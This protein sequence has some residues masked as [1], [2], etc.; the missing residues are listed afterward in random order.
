MDGMDRL[1]Y[2]LLVVIAISVAPA[3]S[4]GTSAADPTERWWRGNTHTHTYW[5][6]G[7]A[8][9]EQAVGWYAEHGYHFVVLSDHNIMQFGEKWFPV[10]TAGNRPLRPEHVEALRAKF[11]DDWVEVREVEGGTEMRLKTLPELRERFERPGRF[12]L[13]PGEEVTDRFERHEVHI[14]AVNIGGTIEPQ[15]GS[16]VVDTLQRNIDAILEH[17]RRTGRPVLAHVNHPNFQWSLTAADLAVIRGDRFFEVYNGHRSV[18][19]EGDDDHPSVERMWDEALVLR[20]AAGAPLLYGLATDDA[21]NH[22]HPDGHSVPGRGWIMVRATKLD[23]ASIIAA[24][25]RGDFYASSGVALERIECDETAY[26]VDIAAEP[27]LAYR[28]EFIGARRAAKGQTPETGVV[29]AAT[30]DDPA[31]YRF[32]GDELYVRARVISSRAHPRPYRDGDREMAWGQPFSPAGK[33]S[34]T[35]R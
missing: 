3:L 4:V 8:A 5:S 12:L 24:M 32:R 10:G 13:V 30:E 15:H 7:D 21:H 33:K 2:V 17:G 26:R 14:N 34:E 31:V 18:R 6:D 25:R 20:L 29:L 9:P 22:H 1:P 28:T 23:E 16:S 35:G 19:N 27:G 11:G